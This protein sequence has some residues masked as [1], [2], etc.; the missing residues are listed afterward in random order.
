[1]NENEL[2]LLSVSVYCMCLAT[3]GQCVS[4]AVS[5][6]PFSKLPLRLLHATFPIITHLLDRSAMLLPLPHTDA[7]HVDTKQ[8]ERESQDVRWLLNN[9]ELCERAGVCR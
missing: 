3:V 2:F 4:G 9:S 8:K 6:R 5:D 7:V 1:M